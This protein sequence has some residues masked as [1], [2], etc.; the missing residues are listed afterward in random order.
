MRPEGP[1]APPCARFELGAHRT[2]VEAFRGLPGHA[3][4]PPIGRLRL[5]R[6]R[7]VRRPGAAR[8]ARTRARGRRPPIVRLSTQS[9]PNPLFHAL[10]LRIPIVNLK[11]RTGHESDGRQYDEVCEAGCHRL[12]PGSSASPKRRKPAPS[13]IFTFVEAISSARSGLLAISSPTGP[14]RYPFR[15]PD[16]SSGQGGK[17]LLPDRVVIGQQH[18]IPVPH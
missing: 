13:G 9:L 18:D 16:R 17:R 15:N 1:P 3:P 6:P 8:P 10:A 14:R 11:L 4:L 7:K 5:V 12:F 2:R